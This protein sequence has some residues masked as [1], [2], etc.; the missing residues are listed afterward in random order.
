MGNNDSKIGPGDIIYRKNN[1]SPL[2]D[3]YGIYIG[4]KG[5]IYFTGEGVKLSSLGNFVEGYEIH[6]KR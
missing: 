6:F 3:L 4:E 1:Q 2:D 5:V